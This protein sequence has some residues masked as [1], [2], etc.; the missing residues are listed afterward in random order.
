[1]LLLVVPALLE[2]VQAAEI[3]VPGHFPTIQAALDASVDGDTVI[4]A[5]GTY[6]ENIVFRGKNVTVRSNDPLDPDVVGATIIDGGQAGACVTFN[7]NESR[8]AAV[9][10]LTLKN[11]TIGVLCEGASPN[12]S[13]NIV[14]D[15]SQYGVRTSIARTQGVYNTLAPGIA[16]NMILNNVRGISLSAGPNVPASVSRN[17]LRG[18]GTGITID[19]SISKAPPARPAALLVG[20]HLSGNLGGIVS[21]LSYESVEIMVVDN[22]IISNAGGITLSYGIA[23]GNTVIDS[24][25]GIWALTITNNAIV[26]NIYGGASGIVVTDNIIASNG[27]VPSWQGGGG[28]LCPYPQGI[29][30]GNHIADNTNAYQGYPYGGGIC[31]KYSSSWV[32]SDNVISG[33]RAVHGGGIYYDRGELLLLRNSIFGN[34]ADVDGGGVHVDDSNGLNLTGNVIAGNLAGGTGGAFNVRKTAFSVRWAQLTGNIFVSNQGGTWNSVFV[35]ANTQNASMKVVDCIFDEASDPPEPTANFNFDLFPDR[36]RLTISHSLIRGGEASISHNAMIYTY[37]PGN[38]DADP[39]FVDPG[40]WDGDTFIVGDYRL[41]PGSACIDAGTNDVDNPGTTP[42]ETLPATD[43]AGLPRII[44]GDLDGAATVDIGAYEY[45]PGDVNYDGKVNV[46]DL[47]LVRNSIGRDP[48]SSVDARN[49]DVNADGA[50]NVDDLLA[51]RGR[52]GR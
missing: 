24:N 9:E 51:V 42:I 32:V 5:P 18:N 35:V 28:V 16:D 13:K 46:L 15:N 23:S 3:N 41:L 52:L 10:G 14:R 17:E 22:T 45:L 26:G 20:N 33:N 43:I 1:M 19:N 12:I 50:V 48:A 39:L 34:K 7:S 30:S 36:G 49:A 29:I 4:V 27:R 8:E 47:L 31:M 21:T 37:G 6:F 40:H 25:F 11:G 2:A 38:I 44:D